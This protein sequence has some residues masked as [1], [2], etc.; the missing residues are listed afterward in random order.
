MKVLFVVKNEECRRVEELLKSLRVDYEK[1]Y[2]DGLKGSVLLEY[3]TEKVPL[4]VT[5]KSVLVGYEAIREAIT[6]E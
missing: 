3:G 5:E 6:R 4:L 1:V 2:V